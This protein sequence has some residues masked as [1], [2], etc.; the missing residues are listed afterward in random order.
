MLRNTAW[1]K[2]EP[3]QIVTFTYKSKHDK[4]G[5]KRTVLILNPDLKYKKK[6]TNRTKRYVV[7]LQLDTAISTPITQTKLEGLFGK[8]GGL[9]IEEGALAAK[10]PDS[11]SPA[12]TKVLYN[13]LKDLVKKYKNWRTYDRRECMKR[14]VYLESESDLIPQDTLDKFTQE[15]V[16]RFGDGGFDYEYEETEF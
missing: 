1:H 3:G 6:S 8:M 5:Y 4:R 13:K 16:D 12:Q 2:V 9:E 10:L 14:R 15:M 11:M 7:G